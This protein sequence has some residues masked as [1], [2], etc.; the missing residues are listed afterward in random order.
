MAVARGVVETAI[1]EHLD[2]SPLEVVDPLAGKDP[3]AVARG[4]KGG[5]IGGRRRAIT[6]SAAKRTKIAKK[7]A[8]TRWHSKIPKF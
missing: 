4:R 7:A 1:G 8:K 2:G 6:M 5:L 3:A